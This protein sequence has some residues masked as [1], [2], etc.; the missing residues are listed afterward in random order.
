[1]EYIQKNAASAGCVF[2]D[3][4]ASDD[5]SSSFILHRAR[6]NYIVMNIYPYTTGHLLITPY[7]HTADFASAD[8]A[9]TDE[10]MDLAKRCQSALAEVYRPE[11]FN[12]GMNLGRAAG[13]GIVDHF[14]MHVLP[15]WSGDTN[16]TTTVGEIRILPEEL[17]S[18]YNKLKP[19]FGEG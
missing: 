16:F 10:M 5:D 17:R 6:L 3:L 13:A 7:H 19:Y 18:T 14:H 2:C 12:L 9:T 4:P 8:K 11:G 1:M 15:R